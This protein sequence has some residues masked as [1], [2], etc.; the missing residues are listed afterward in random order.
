MKVLVFSYYFPPDLSAGSFRI[1]ALVGA[2]AEADEVTVI[3]TRPNRYASLAA[4]AP[5]TERRGRV[6][7][8][9]LPVSAHSG[10]MASQARSYLGFMLRA[11]PLALRSEADVVFVTSSRL[12]TAV[13]AAVVS[14][15]KRRPLYLDVRD[16]FVDTIFDVIRGRWFRPFRPLLS[17]LER[18]VVARAARINLVSPGFLGYFGP[19]YPRRSFDLFTN[20]I[21]TGFLELWERRAVQVRAPGAPFTVL[22][23]GN[24]GDG[25]GIHHF[26]PDVAVRLG[27][28][29]QFLIYGDGGK[30]A[31]LREA[32]AARGTS[33][34]ELRPPIPREA[35][36]AAYAS[37]D[38]LLVHLNDYPAFLR[39]LPSKLFEY[40]ATGLPILA[41]VGGVAADLV[42]AD[43]PDAILFAPLDS[44]ALMAG[45][46]SLMMR[47][48]A[49]DRAKPDRA[50]FIDK[51]LRPRISAQIAA[52]IRA[53]AD[54]RHR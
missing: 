13:L 3:T 20:G 31:V 24:I 1:A 48:A 28:R 39:V 8:H 5:R 50:A 41:G 54:S 33:N 47:G 2:L 30:L 11:V 17:L 40:G 25:Q 10:G 27:W 6:S 22:Y 34:V 15:L 43:L 52:A 35:L 9:R 18:F 16:I 12:F 46:D 23:A 38:A 21:D 37:A 14:L 19:R 44:E 29:V 45:I 26:L 49:P 7:I 51:Y 36:I 32:L 4:E 53:T 42:A